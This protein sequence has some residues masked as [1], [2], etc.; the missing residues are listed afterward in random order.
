MNVFQLVS[1]KTWGG[2]EQYAFDLVDRLRHDSTK[3]VEVV[4]RKT[5]AV[6][7]RF[8]RLEIPISIL[9]LKGVYDFD[10]PVR[11]ARLIGKGQNIVHVHQLS[12]AM[13]A[14]LARRISENRNTRIV[15][16]VHGMYKPRNNYLWRKIYRSI[17]AVIFP[18]QAARERFVD[19]SRGLDT[20]KAVVIGESVQPRALTTPSPDLRELMDMTPS[21]ALLLYHGR[22]HPDKGI[23]TLLR[24]VTQLDKDSF[25]LVIAGK[26]SP[27]Y[28][29]QLKGFIV[30][31]QLVRNVRFIG[32]QD[33]VDQCI[34][35][36]DIGV[37]PST[38]PEALGITGLEYMMHGKPL[39][40]S[41]NGAQPE[42]VDHGVNGLLVDPSN[43]TQLAAALQRL[44]DDTAYRNRIGQ[45]A[46]DDFNSRLNYDIFYDRLTDLYQQVINRKRKIENE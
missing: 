16:S 17:D 25:R 15:M 4:C 18:S 34:S 39:I 2:A 11:F 30:A 3:Y 44:I 13:T 26:G 9:P 40:T 41:N 6:L 24:A 1:D 36:C 35:Q 43:Y 28:L 22:I 37:L 29:A 20:S 14:A 23:D 21:Q 32:F 46:L 31:N 33:N 45:Q 5:P 27:K 12:D 8:R 7:N 38:A 42:Y 10:S 19:A